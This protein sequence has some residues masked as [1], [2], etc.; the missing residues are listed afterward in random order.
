MILVLETAPVIEPISKAEL[1]LHLRLP[2]S[3]VEDT[4]LDDIIQAARENIEDMTRRALLTQTWDMYLSRFPAATAI[5]LPFGNLQSV[6]HV[7]YTDSDG[8]QTT[9]TE[10]T[11]YTVET[12]GDQC[13]FVRLP[14]SGPWPS[15][16]LDPSNP[17]VIR[18]VCGWTEAA[19]LPSKIRTAVKMI[20]HD[21][22]ENRESQ[23]FEMSG[24]YVENRTAQLL[25]ASMRLMDEIGHTE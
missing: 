22:Y 18:F 9:L 2:A 21:L 12:N 17:V 6:T 15:A 13:G 14:Y 25:L 4:L 3:E 24:Q 1:K 5:K 16:T 20:C 19:S 23:A 10:D 7:K 11:D 8:D